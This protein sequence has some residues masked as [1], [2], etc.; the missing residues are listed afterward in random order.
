MPHATT[1]NTP[2]P[3]CVL[4]ATCQTALKPWHFPLDLSWVSE[5]EGTTDDRA[6][7]VWLEI[8]PS[9]FKGAEN[10]PCVLSCP[11]YGCSTAVMSQPIQVVMTDSSQRFLAIYCW[12]SLLFLQF[13][14]ET[15]PS[16]LPAS[17][18][19]HQANSLWN[20]KLH[21]RGDSGE[22]LLRARTAT[23]TPHS[24]GPAAGCAQD[25]E[26]LPRCRKRTASR[27][28]THYSY[29]AVAAFTGGAQVPPEEKRGED[30]N[31]L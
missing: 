28:H 29:A 6:V 10:P 14:Q 27:S 21:C 18:C 26:G 15:H 16:P 30:E 2:N 11:W 17:P 12:F 9:S 19:D 1:L 3:C 22:Q 23:G 25:A 4:A 24:S 13:Y 20:S 7:H 5:D 31:V 8:N